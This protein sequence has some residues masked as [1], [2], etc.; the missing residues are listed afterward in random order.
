MY[1]KIKIYV[2]C[3]MTADLQHFKANTT[4]SNGFVDAKLNYWNI[5][6]TAG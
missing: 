5:I 3:L 2:E 4:N 6:T 1:H